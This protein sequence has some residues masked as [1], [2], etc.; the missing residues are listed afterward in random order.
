MQVDVIK[1]DCRLCK[2]AQLSCPLMVQHQREA[3]TA[4]L[5]GEVA[6][7]SHLDP[8][9]HQGVEG[10]FAPRSII[11]TFDVLQVAGQGKGSPSRSL[12]ASPRPSHLTEKAAQSSLFDGLEAS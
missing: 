8:R 9:W 7:C 5:N 12:T 3:I 1:T 4:H 2:Q 10:V 11:D 6:E